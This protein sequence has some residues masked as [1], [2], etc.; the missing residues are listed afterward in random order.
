MNTTKRLW[1][2]GGLI[3]SV[4]VGV[5]ARA[6]FSQ[7]STRPGDSE[8]G[9]YQLFAVEHH[10]GDPY[11]YLLDTKTGRSWLRDNNFQWGESGPTE[12]R[13]R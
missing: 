13:N 2:I 5:L 3:G 8:V 9:R 10:A 7:A 12:L 11:L 6:S 4:A 1:V